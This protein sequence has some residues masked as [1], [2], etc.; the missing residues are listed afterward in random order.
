MSNDPIIVLPHD[1]VWPSRFV[2]E[3]G[4]LLAIFGDALLGLHHIGST[5]VPGLVAK[6]ILDVAL[7][8]RSLALA[9]ARRGPAEAAGF[10]WRGEAGVSG[11]R[12][13]EAR[14]RAGPEDDA[15][16]VHVHAFEAGT[17]QAWRHVD[18]RDYLL[19]HPER[20]DAYGALKGELA[21]RFRDDRAG[22]TDA[23]TAFVRETEALARAW[24]G[25]R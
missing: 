5:A 13:L 15:Y 1:P 12:Y 22:Y 24:R 4:G 23:K 8:V 21:V 3:A 17:P 18:F 19:H 14:R 11:R 20:A 9:D 25:G 6:P 2:R 7:D 16:V 10:A